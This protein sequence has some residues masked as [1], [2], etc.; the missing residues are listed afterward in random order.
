MGAHREEHH[1]AGGGA[2]GLGQAE[3]LADHGLFVEVGVILVA[4]LDLLVAEH[5]GHLV[6]GQGVE[7]AMADQRF[8]GAGAGDHHAALELL[9]IS[10]P[11]FR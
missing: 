8:G 1:A 10:V 4:A 5:H 6:A 7:A 9:H 3:G 11:P 2:D